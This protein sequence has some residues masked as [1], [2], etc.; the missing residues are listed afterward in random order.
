MDEAEGEIWPNPICI[1]WS[2]TRNVTGETSAHA[3]H[4]FGAVKAKV[5]FD[6]YKKH[7]AIAPFKAH[8][9][10]LNAI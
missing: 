7:D 6:A 4:K 3:Q 1:T 2:P 10:Q 9:M 5:D 8:L